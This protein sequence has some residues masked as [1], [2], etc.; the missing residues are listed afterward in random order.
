MEENFMIFIS[1]IKKQVLSNYHDPITKIKKDGFEEIIQLE[2]NDNDITF[3][4]TKSFKNL[5]SKIE[6]LERIAD[7]YKLNFSLYSL[8]IQYFFYFNL[9]FE[10]RG[11]ASFLF[12]KSKFGTNL[13]L[14]QQFFYFIN[15]INDDNKKENQ[16]Q[17]H[18]ALIFSTLNFIFLK[19]TNNFYEEKLFDILLNQ[20]K[21]NEEKLII[22]SIIIS[23]WLK[24]SKKKF[25]FKQ[26]I[27]I[28]KIIRTYFL[29][30]EIIENYDEKQN[31]N[32]IIEKKKKIVFKN[33]SLC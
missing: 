6:I 28:L 12:S 14:E 20:Y 21:I 25:N 17:L 7:L 4:F 23:N 9:E 2:E 8:K 29:I 18:L 33:K 22:I 30:Y 15:Y 3:L 1:T 24:K 31:E 10:R 11:I 19:N 13:S 26:F 27:D 32:K 5:P 16:S